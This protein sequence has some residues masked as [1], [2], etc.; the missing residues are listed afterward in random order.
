MATD[1][2]ARGLA[3]IRDFEKYRGTSYLDAVK[4]WT[5][6][7]GTTRINGRPVVAGMT[8][9]PEQAEQWLRQDCQEAID[10]VLRG[11][12]RPLTQ[13]QLDA[14]VSFVYNVGLGGFWDSS[15]RRAINASQPIARD[16]FTRWNKGRVNGQLVVLPGLTRR[17]NDE[18]DIFIAP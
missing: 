3:F 5:I 10:G 13:N 17:R 12:T 16:L 18:Y 4:V 6:G 1:I 7:Y 15:L 8:C 14:L 11:T 2:S 9:T